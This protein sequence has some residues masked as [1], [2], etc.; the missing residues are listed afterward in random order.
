MHHPAKKKTGNL[1][2][3]AEAWPLL[4]F[5]RLEYSTMNNLQNLVPFGPQG[6]CFR[7]NHR[8][9]SVKKGVLRNFLENSQESTC[10]RASFLIKL[11]APATLLKKKLWHRCFPVNFAKFQRTSFFT[12]HHWWLLLN[13]EFKSFFEESTLF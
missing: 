2:H 11:Q 1:I 9:C 3:R 5:I 4:K 12:E 13:S 7:S 6:R 8:R 10:A